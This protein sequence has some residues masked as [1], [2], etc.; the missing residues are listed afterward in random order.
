MRSIEFA[1]FDPAPQQVTS[2]FDAGIRFTAPD[3]FFPRRCGILAS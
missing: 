2:G 3:I 1:V